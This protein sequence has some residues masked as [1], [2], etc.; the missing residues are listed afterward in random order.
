[1]VKAI[2]RREGNTAVPSG[3]ASLEYLHAIKDGT[4]FIA[5]THGARNL[6]Q[7]HLSLIHI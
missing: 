2:W 1:M 6:K 5:E 4:E 3:A 7:L